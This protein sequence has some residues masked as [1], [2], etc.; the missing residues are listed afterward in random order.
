[1]SP[2]LR[3]WYPPC[4]IPLPGR[5][6]PLSRAFLGEGEDALSF[7]SLA[8]NQFSRSYGE[9][10]TGNA[11][12]RR[13]LPRLPGFSL[14]F[15]CMTDSSGAFQP[16]CL[17]LLRGCPSTRLCVSRGTD[18]SLEVTRRRQRSRKLGING[19]ISCEGHN[20]VHRAQIG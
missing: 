11:L 8:E 3:G 5:G 6:S 13:Q 10:H 1:M 16:C 9:V 7:S 14:F 17:P 4:L 20:H 12:P 18:T 19:N 15:C 2:G